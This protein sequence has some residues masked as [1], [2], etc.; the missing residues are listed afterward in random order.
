MDQFTCKLPPSIGTTASS[1]VDAA[2]GQGPQHGIGIALGGHVNEVRG[3]GG[4]G[5]A[6]EGVEGVAGPFFE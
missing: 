3:E 4:V 6:Q 1:D 5:K 2:F